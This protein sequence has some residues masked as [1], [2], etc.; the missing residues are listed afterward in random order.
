M[1]KDRS[2]PL[3]G[4]ISDRIRAGEITEHSTRSVDRTPDAPSTDS[5]R[6]GSGHGLGAGATRARGGDES[7]K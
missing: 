7:G 5:V 1:G 2:Q 6:H 4:K 3:G